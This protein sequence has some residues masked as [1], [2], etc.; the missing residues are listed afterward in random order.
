MKFTILLI[1]AVALCGCKRLFGPEGTQAADGSDEVTA[2][3]N[4]LAIAG[5]AWPLAAPLLRFV[6]VVGPILQAVVANVSWSALATK[7]QKIEDKGT[8]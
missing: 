3:Q 6:P 1:A 5:Y 4:W 8:I 2:T 7:Q